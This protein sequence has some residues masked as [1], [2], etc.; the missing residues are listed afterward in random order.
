M[1]ARTFDTETLA[2][3]PELDSI[4]YLTGISN[5]HTRTAQQ[6]R[7]GYLVTPES[8]RAAT[9]TK[10]YEYHAAD[11]GCFNSSKPGRSFD[12]D[13]WL[14][15]LGRVEL[16]GCLFAVLP[17]VLEWVTDPETNAMF[18]I[19]NCDATIERSALYVDVVKSMGFPAAVV[20]QDGLDDL[21]RVPFAAD[22]V[23]IGGS[24]AYKLGGDAASVTAQA[25]ARGMWVHMGRVNSG[26]RLAYAASI[27]CDSADGTFLK[28]G[29]TAHAAEQFARM[30]RFF[31]K[32][33]S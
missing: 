17:D 12:P 11:N 9:Q 6:S 3:F 21:D 10:F 8:D 28:Y 13:A 24:D 14:R 30:M 15:W 7:L 29:G 31:D 26:K 5:E 33:G 19:G 1:Q 27:G 23:F 16:R 2:D 22:A 32:V 4:V 18:P 25:K 20:A